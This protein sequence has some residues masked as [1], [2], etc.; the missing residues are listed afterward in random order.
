MTEENGIITVVS[1][2][3]GLLSCIGVPPSFTIFAFLRC[4]RRSW[5]FFILAIRSSNL[6]SAALDRDSRYRWQ[7]V[8]LLVSLVGVRVAGWR[9]VIGKRRFFLYQESC[10][11]IRTNDSWIADDF[12]LPLIVDLEVNGCGDSRDGTC[13]KPCVLSATPGGYFLDPYSFL[14]PDP[15]T[16]LD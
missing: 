8:P 16:I 7:G 1:G 5:F 12:G 15:T 2:F 14:G 13:D 9:E 3:S 4:K 6:I 11:D 10:P